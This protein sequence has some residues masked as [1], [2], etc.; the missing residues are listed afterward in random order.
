VTNIFTEMELLNFMLTGLTK[1]KNVHFVL[2]NY[3]IWT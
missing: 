1:A 3:V 2:Y